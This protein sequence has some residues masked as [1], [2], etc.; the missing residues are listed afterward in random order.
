MT[1]ILDWISD[2]APEIAA[3][4]STEKKNRFI[5]IAKNEID[6]TV[7]ISSDNYNLAV[8]YYTCHLLYQSSSGGDLVGALIEEKEGDLMRKYATVENNN[9]QGSTQYLESYYRMIKARV[10]SFYINSGS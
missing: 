1:S 10:P 3:N 9:S 6:P 5:A 4:N 7:F 8:A 2:I